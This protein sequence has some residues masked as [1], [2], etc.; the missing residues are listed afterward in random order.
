MPE[1]LSSPPVARAVLAGGLLAGALLDGTLRTGDLP[2]AAR[3]LGLPERGRYAVVVVSG[4]TAS[5]RIAW[6]GTVV[7]AG[8]TCR[9][10]LGAGADHGIVLLDRGDATLDRLAQGVELRRA[11]P[12]VLG[13]VRVG[14]G[15]P[16]TGLGALDVARR[17]ADVALAACPDGPVARLHDHLPAALVQAGP[18]LASALAVRVLGPLL[19]LPAPERGVLL[20]TLAVWL[21]GD[22][23]TGQAARRLGCHRNTV[24]NRLQR[25]ERLTGRCLARPADVVEVGLALS[26]LRLAGQGARGEPRSSRAP[27]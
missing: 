9:W 21:D 7:P 12:S 23:V 18:D 11:A 26:A 15:L 5:D 6:H 8:L 13:P 24:R 27:W 17:H 25:C 1:T 4:G 16:V 3:V 2:E 19:R 14:V 10:R 22:G 20:D